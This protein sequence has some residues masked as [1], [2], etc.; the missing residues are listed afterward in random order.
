MAKAPCWK[1]NL[2]WP[3][4]RGHNYDKTFMFKTTRQSLSYANLRI[5]VN[6]WRFISIF[7]PSRLKKSRQRLSQSVFCSGGDNNPGLV[8]S[9]VEESAHHFEVN[10]SIVGR[11]SRGFIAKVCQLRKKKMRSVLWL[12]FAIIKVKKLEGYQINSHMSTAQ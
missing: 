4:L 12:P 5:V 7:Q 6:F 2:L 11:P 3:G 9:A 10:D 8:L 1:K